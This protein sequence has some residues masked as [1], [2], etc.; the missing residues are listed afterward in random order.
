MLNSAKARTNLGWKPVWTLEQTL[1]RIVEWHRAQLAG[2]DMRVRCLEEIKAY[3]RDA[4]KLV[5]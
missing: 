5:R 2:A 1:S 3:N 4:L